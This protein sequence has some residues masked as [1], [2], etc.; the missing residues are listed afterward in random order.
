MNVT[1]FIIRA[2]QFFGLFCF[3]V[4]ILVAAVCIRIYRSYDIPSKEDIM[5]RNDTGLVLMDRNG[6]PFFT[7]NRSRPRTF[8]PLSRMPQQLQQAVVATEDKDFYHHIGFS[9]K[10]IARS[11]YLDI[12]YGHLYYGGSTLTQQLVKNSLLTTQKS[13]KRKLAEVI[14]A[15][16]L[17]R[18]FSKQDILEM[19]L[20]S[21]YFGKGVFGVEEA[22][23]AYFN[24]SASEL[25]LSESAMLA[26]LLPSPTNFSPD[27]SDQHSGKVHQ[28]IVL[29]HM[30]SAG[31]IS[32]D[33]AQKAYDDPIV[34][35]PHNDDLNIH[36]PHFALMVRDQ[37]YKIYGEENVVR[38][39]LK[40][41]TTLDLEWQKYAQ[42]AVAKQVAKLAGGGATNGAVVV[43]DPTNGEVRALVGS[44]NWFDD[45]YGKVNMATTPR[46][47]GSAFKPIV[48][49]TAFEKHVITPSTLLFDIPTT[50]GDTYNPK[51][52]DLK[53]RGPVLVRRALANSLNVPAV[54]VIAQTG[55][56][57]VAAMAQR[58]GIS[59]ITNP[60]SYNLSMALGTEQISLLELTN[61]YATFAD[62]GVRH[63]P[64]L[65][66]ELHDKYNRPV[67]FI[68]P[69][70]QPALEP[71][72]AFLVS[73]ILSDNKARAEIFGK[74]LTISRP[75]AAKTGTTQDYRDAWTVGYVPQMAVG[76]WIGNNDNK[77]MAELPGSVGAAPVWR[78][79][80]EHVA[81][82]LPVQDF[83]PPAG[84]VAARVCSYDGG[85][86][87]GNSGGTVEYF[88]A[89]TEPTR[90]CSP[91]PAPSPSA[92]PDG[93]AAPQPLPIPP[94]P[95]TTTKPAAPKPA[96][97]DN[98]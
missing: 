3:V 87:P 60:Q 67:P 21:A 62:N 10:A 49:A 71:Q 98:G 61:A 36:A 69:T 72:V 30:I 17:E 50:F 2:S 95:V 28:K 29:E 90:Y 23:Q 31:Y 37:L 79:V 91:P 85:L 19:Y 20:N 66:S 9:P 42:D 4:F 40:V 94:V 35:H 46:Q 74:L 6:T 76:V 70:P 78:D 55:V 89:G 48:Y 96:L 45:T 59:T 47:T 44:V 83:A 41:R 82:S 26:G 13:F 93:S 56:T 88:L 63:M 22:A 80:L 5:N 58:L 86:I 97:V 65:F 68:P 81:A 15:V 1:R 24:K 25:T 11:A 16:K 73:S 52:Y 43:E 14:I 53:W 64:L 39:G 92:A 32:K 33:L 57:D 75:A 38:A 54:E 34:L 51:D 77:P 12:K 27:A 18:H 7:F 84:V 8:I